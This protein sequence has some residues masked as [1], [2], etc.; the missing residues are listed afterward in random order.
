MSKNNYLWNFFAIIK[1]AQLNKKSFIVCKKTKLCENFLKLFWNNGYIIGYK[2]K[3]KNKLKI[4]LKYKQNKPVIYSLKIVSKPNHRIY[5]SN[6]QLWKINSGR[7]L[8]FLST[9]YGLKSLLE[10]KK[11]N[12]GG[13]LFI[14]LN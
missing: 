14:V 9:P 1:N 7:S 13:E 6:Q 11:I 10:C 4:F 12:S 3:Q 8:L 2:V 5:Y